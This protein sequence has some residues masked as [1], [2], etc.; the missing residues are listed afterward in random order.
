V[1]DLRLFLTTWP[2]ARDA[3][4][5]L[6]TRVAEYD[7]VVCSAS[8][9]ANDGDA[10]PALDPLSTAERI[11]VAE[12]RDAVEAKRFASGRRLVRD[13]LGEVL[14]R[15][16]EDVPIRSGLWDKPYLHLAD[17]ERT[18]WFSV[19]HAG[20]LLVVALSR[21]AEVGVDIELTRPI[22]Q[23]QRLADRVLDSRS[24]AHLDR[25]V[26]LGEDPARAFLQ[27]WCRVEAE[28]KALGGG[29]GSLDT[30]HAGV[31]PARLRLA[32]LPDLPFPADRA[33]GAER[34]QAAVALCYGRSAIH[35]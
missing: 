18:L 4:A 9:L 35:A 29:L 6:A 12:F 34:Y 33:A 31:H 7:V 1:S 11:R 14:G 10:D 32:D 27:F 22:A 15:S 28:V 13:V 24:R 2:V 8:L 20:E 21:V 5:D 26:E 30:C 17:G 19:S 25:I 16:P 23:W 3:E